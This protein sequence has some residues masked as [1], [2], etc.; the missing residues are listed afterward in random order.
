MSR[1]LS[2]YPL[3][4]T[5]QLFACRDFYVRHFGFEV[6]F[7]ASW[8]VWLTKPAAEGGVALAF[9]HPD[10]P[11]MPP[12]P[13]AFDGRGLLLTLQVDDAAAEAARLAAAGVAIAYPLAVEPWGQRRFQVIDPAGLVLDVVEQVEPEAGF[14][15]RYPAPGA[16]A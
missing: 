5:P 13:E 2:A 6:G 16:A 3:I 11:S 10:H 12:G 15:A 4:T 1:L 9:M 14:W 7:E 8:F